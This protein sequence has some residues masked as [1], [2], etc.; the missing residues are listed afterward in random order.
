MELVVLGLG[1]NR[2]DSKAILAGAVKCLHGILTDL[3]SAP[4]FETAPQG[5]VDQ[6]SFLNMA[7][8][9]SCA[10]TPEELL[11]IVHYI[12]A[13]FGRDRIRERHWG[14]RTLDIDIL[15][16]GRRVLSGP[17]LTIPHPRLRE[18]AFA[19]VPLLALLPKATDPRTGEPYARVLEELPGQDVKQ[20]KG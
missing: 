8:C 11:E 12:E 1:S 14:E 13:A 6:P 15:L 19:L 17:S 7:V 10:L 18:R 20:F 3:R 16:F 9:G 5:I 2:G 4:M